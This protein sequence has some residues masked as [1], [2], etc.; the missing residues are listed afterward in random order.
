MVNSS[1]YLKRHSRKHTGENFQCLYC[2]YKTIHPDNLNRHSRKHT[3]E[4]F[5][6]QQCDYKT[7]DPVNLNRHSREHTCEPCI[8]SVCQW[9]R[10]N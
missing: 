7:I 10:R 1:C 5:K 6:C 4:I 2:D 8:F 9:L 3:G